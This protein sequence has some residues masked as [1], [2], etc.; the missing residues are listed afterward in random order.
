MTRF[1]A[2]PSVSSFFADSPQ[3]G[4][5]S[6]KLMQAKS[7]QRQAATQAESFV[8]RSGL[9]SM[10]RIR[11]AEAQARAT[12]A[13]AAGDA[14]ATRSQGMSSMFGSIAGGI[15]SMDFGGGGGSPGIGTG[16]EFG[17]VGTMG[18]DMYDFNYTPAQ[19][20]AFNN[21]TGVYWETP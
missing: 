14:S 16:A 9:D 20:I 11:T 1:A 5:I 6:D 18:S 3:Y 10:E 2:G 15:G 13:G 8:E 4:V 7:Q 21:G 12:A 17:E 19:D